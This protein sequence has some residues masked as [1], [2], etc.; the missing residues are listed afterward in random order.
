MNF[1]RFV[2]I[3]YNS[4]IFLKFLAISLKVCEKFLE[5]LWNFF[6]E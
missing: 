2:S 6:L 5:K 1:S 4:E 3:L